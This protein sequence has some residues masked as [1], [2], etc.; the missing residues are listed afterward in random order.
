MDWRRA[1]RYPRTALAE[2]VFAGYAGLADAV[3]LAAAGV[4]AVGYRV[5]P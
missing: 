5:G 4:L 3:G 1:V 2:G